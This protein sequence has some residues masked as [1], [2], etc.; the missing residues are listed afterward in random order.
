MKTVTISKKAYFFALSLF[1]CTLLLGGCGM[2]ECSFCGQKRFCKEF[3]LL[4]TTRYICDDCLHNP[5]LAVSGNVTREYS[6]LYENGTL[7]YP[8]GSP[9]REQISE[10][11]PEETQN[12]PTLDE[13]MSTPSAIPG[14]VPDAA[15]SVGNTDTAS[16]DTPQDTGNDATGGD[17]PQQAQDNPSSQA[18]TSQPSQPD[19][20]AD[21]NPSDSNPSSDSSG[22]DTMP[23]EDLIRDLNRRF[24]ADGY[25]IAQDNDLEN[26]YRM[27]SGNNDLHIRLTPRSTGS[28]GEYE[29]TVSQLADASSSDYVKC[30]IRSVLSYVDSEDYD[31][32]G[33]DIYNSTIQ[34]GSYSY[35]G[36]SFSYI[37][38]TA[39]EIERGS[40]NADF[41]IR[42]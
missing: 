38:H 34:N 40:A 39:D 31:G 5:A 2:Q 12:G 20:A 7:E 29:L 4:G 6:A 42:P 35:N 23:A 33:H 28:S 24:Q 11:E 30:V 1:V 19:T 25:R 3:D 36:V 8:E 32:L 26:A 22:D 15:P 10:T 18:E 9:F 13:I 37:S 17:S 14:S 21:H 27:L 41:V 16:A